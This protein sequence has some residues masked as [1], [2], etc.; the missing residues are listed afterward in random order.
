M[1]GLEKMKKQGITDENNR[2]SEIIWTDTKRCFYLAEE[3]QWE[4]SRNQF[5]LHYWE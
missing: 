1:F 2:I 5:L 4:K 3:P